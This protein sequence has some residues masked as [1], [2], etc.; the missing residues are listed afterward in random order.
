MESREAAKN[1]TRKIAIGLVCSAWFGLPWGLGAFSR[2]SRST[3]ASLALK[4][5]RIERF[6]H[7]D[8]SVEMLLPESSEALI[9]E[10]EF[11]EDERLPYWAELWPAARGLTRYLLELP[12][13]P[14]PTLELGCGVGLPSLALLHRGVEVLAS[15][16]Y[17]DALAFASMNAE[18]NGLPPLA[19]E[20]LDWR[21]P[22]NDVRRF[23]LILAADVL[24]EARNAVA[25]ATLLPG[26]LDQHG[27]F[28]L[29]DPGRAY[30]VDF[31]DRMRSAGWSIETLPER[32]EDAPAGGGLQTR[33]QLFRL[34]RPDEPDPA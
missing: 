20:V 1:R 5:L 7:L 26:L 33:V 24:Y 12:H 15:D 4:P 32:C 21:K 17:T 11:D 25:L 28:L 13:L 3:P 23:A 9:D 10:A 19:T 29:A 2:T 8:F 34:R 6:S 30:L 16:Y 14:S 31:L 22:A 18:R 27:A